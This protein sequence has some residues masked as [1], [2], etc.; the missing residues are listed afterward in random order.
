MSASYPNV[1]PPPA[2]AA[3][4][5]TARVPWTVGEAIATLLLAFGVGILLT[6]P[7]LLV[8]D[9]VGLSQ[10]R[11]NA[12][13][14]P[15]TPLVLGVVT[16]TVVTARHRGGLRRLLGPGRPSPRDWAVGFGVAIVGYLGLNL[17][18][19]SLLQFLAETAGFD[20][21]V[22]QQTFR[23]A[24]ADPANAW[25]LAFGALLLAPLAE[26]LLYRGMLFQALRDR[27]GAGWGI[28]LSAAVFAATHVDFGGTWLSNAML[29]G[30][31]WPLGA[32]L[33]W[34]FHRRGT[35]LVPIVAH[36]VFNAIN[37]SLL[38]M[39]PGPT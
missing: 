34:A 21:P 19:G 6:L 12:V 31:I 36:A 7:L 1:P 10:G 23:D 22:V 9:A 24:A 32:L 26:E 28:W 11:L 27:L 4:A 20:P 13:A 18:F 29:V 15:L 17:A 35:L 8:G 14:I 2:S 3:D 16:L 30:V 5:T 37:V 25:I 39:G 33:A 38:V